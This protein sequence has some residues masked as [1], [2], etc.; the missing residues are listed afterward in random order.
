[1]NAEPHIQMMDFLREGQ[2]SG[3]EPDPIPDE[4][5]LNHSKTYYTEG[6]EKFF[7]AM[8]EDP[9][10]TGQMKNRRLRY[11]P[12]VEALRAKVA[13][14]GRD[15]EMPYQGNLAVWISVH[16]PKHYINRVDL[17]NMTKTLLDC[18]KGILFVDDRQVFEIEASKH[19]NEDAGLLFGVRRIDRH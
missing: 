12:F 14:L 16:G 10:P 19:V 1:M 3:I 6:W 2:V 5:K 18:V 13:L 8:L 9:L 7:I 11:R 4:D 15:P 17:D